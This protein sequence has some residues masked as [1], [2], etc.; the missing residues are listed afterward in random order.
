MTRCASP[1]PRHP[2]ARCHTIQPFQPGG[3][4][5]VVLASYPVAIGDVV[6]KKERSVASRRLLR[7]ED[8]RQLP[9]H[10][11]FGIEPP[12]GQIV[13]E[14]SRPATRRPKDQRQLLSLLRAGYDEALAAEIDQLYL[15]A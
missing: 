7:A 10:R 6:R 4:V 3:P 11:V 2:R 9:V 12:A 13:A 8:G 5:P 1:C 14:M 15:V